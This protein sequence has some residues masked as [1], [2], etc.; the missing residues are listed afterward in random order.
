MDNSRTF[1]MEAA[2]RYCANSINPNKDSEG[3]PSQSEI[4]VGIP[5]SW[6]CSL[7]SSEP[8]TRLA[9]NYYKV[10]TTLGVF[11]KCSMT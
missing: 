9:N 2:G 4:V 10:T 5:T 1:D 11:L 6:M 7:P 8:A 3:F